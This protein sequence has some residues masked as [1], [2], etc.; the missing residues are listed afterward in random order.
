MTANASTPL[1]AVFDVGK[2]NSKLSLIDASSC[3]EVWSTQRPNQTVI[4]AVGRELDVIEIEHWL[5]RSLQSA[6]N[7]DRIEAIVPVAHGA[8]AIWVTKTGELLAAPDYEDACYES[9]SDRYDLRRDPYAST[10]SPNLPLG[11]NLGR[12][13]FFIQR[14]RA[15]LFARAAHVLLYPQYWAWRLSGVLASEVTS[16]GCHTDLWQPQQG[17]FSRIASE[18]GWLQL[19]PPLRRANDRLGYIAPQIAA[20]S[21]LDPRCIILCGIHDSNASFL[22]YLIDREHDAFA[23]VSSGTWTIVMANRGELSHLRE[24]RDMLASVNAFG[25]PVPTA[26]FMGGR[27]YEAISN[28]GGMPNVDALAYIIGRGAMALPSFASAGP[29]ANRKGVIL[30]AEGL[31]EAQR[32]TLASLYSALMTSELIDSLRVESEVLIDGPLASNPLVGPLLAAMI[33]GEVKLHADRLGGA[34][35]AIHLAG[36]PV[37]QSETSKVARPLDVP[38]LENYREIWLESLR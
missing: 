23:V 19:M 28:G 12:Q 4:T 27:E 33:P 36:Y 5:L 34:R 38:G 10:F 20:E 1:V 22:K 31:D 7:K 29:F 13:F 25:S 21:G 16:L 24:D 32:A 35:S 8:A 37:T 3:A 15:E 26:R 14:K 2:T 11:L 9:I 17:A 18:E 30:N 6:P